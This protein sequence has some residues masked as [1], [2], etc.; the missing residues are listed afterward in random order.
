VRLFG[1]VTFTRRQTLTL[2]VRQIYIIPCC[3]AGSISSDFEE[4]YKALMSTTVIAGIG[5]IK[6]YP[7]MTAEDVKRGNRPME[8]PFMAFTKS[9]FAIPE[10][11]PG[12]E[13]SRTQYY[14]AKDVQWPVPKSNIFVS[15]SPMKLSLDARTIDWLTLMGLHVSLDLIKKLK[16]LEQFMHGT[17]EPSSIATLLRV[18]CYFP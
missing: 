11:V 4:D 10:T 16:N 2:V 13:L 14:Y 12:I 18:E 17:A 3:S 9:D 5:E 6:I 8:L 15:V 1:K 7:L